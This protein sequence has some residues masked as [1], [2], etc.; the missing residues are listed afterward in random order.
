MTERLYLKTLEHGYAT[1]FHAKVK[2][3]DDDCVTLDRTL[4]YPLGGGQHWDVGVLNGP[5]GLLDV[6]EVRGREDIVHTVGQDHQLGVGDEV[7][8]TVDWSQRY[9]HMRMH[10]AQHVVSGLVYEMFDGART[11]GN[12]IHAH[13][14]RIDFNPISFD[15]AMLSSLTNAVNERILAGL[16]VTD[17]IMTRDAMNAIMPPDRTNMDLLPSSVKELRV[18]EIGDRVDMC[19]CAGTHVTNLAELG[20]MTITGKKSKGKGT[21]RITY[22]LGDPV[23]VRTPTTTTI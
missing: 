16:S 9:A 2:H 11:V 8:G 20:P 19:P 7:T 5:N 6:T 22:E 10:T 1:S 13:R 3:V 14:S 15:E 23:T 21:Q 4:F 12:Q 18:I 17:S